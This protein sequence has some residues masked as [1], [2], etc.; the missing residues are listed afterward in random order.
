MLQMHGM[1]REKQ[2][3]MKPN[4]VNVLQPLI[5]SLLENLTVLLL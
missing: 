2:K 5:S 1:R 3:V 4:P